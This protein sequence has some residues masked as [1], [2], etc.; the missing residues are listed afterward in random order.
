MTG[1]KKRKGEERKRSGR[2]AASGL[3]VLKRVT[4]VGFLT[5]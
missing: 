4:A 3:A 1:A 2:F 5:E